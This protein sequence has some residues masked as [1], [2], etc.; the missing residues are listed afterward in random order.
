VAWI[1]NLTFDQEIRIL[2]NFCYVKWSR[3]ALVHL[4]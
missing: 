3:G 1:M 2:C 4:C